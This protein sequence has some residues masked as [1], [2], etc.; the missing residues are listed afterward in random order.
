M[1]TDASTRRRDRTAILGSIAFHL[2]V[3]SALLVVRPLSVP[4]DE[5]DERALVAQIIRLERGPPRPPVPAKPRAA[6]APT[7]TAPPP[8]PPPIVRTVVAHAK[9]DGPRHVA[10]EQRPASVVALRPSTQPSTRAIAPE[11][12]AAE[13]TANVTRRVAMMAEVAQTPTPAP[14]AAPAERDAG[15]GNFGESYP[16]RP[17]PGTLEALRA[18]L[19]GHA[20]VVRVDVDE[21][22]RATAVLI[23]SGIDD[24]ALRDEV[25]RSLLA[26]GFIPA[27]CNGLGCAATVELRT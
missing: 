22:G 15:V 5:P 18:R 3:L 20:V 23:V 10:A 7:P 1:P 9:N 8:L 12:P 17:M 14:T 13:P 24:P 16:A 2:C 21:H 19:N 25:T 4:A 6:L 27:S 26:A 11:T